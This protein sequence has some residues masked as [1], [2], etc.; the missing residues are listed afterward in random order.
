MFSREKFKTSYMF[1]TTKI[2]FK[3]KIL[4][5]KNI[6]MFDY[7]IKKIIFMKIDVYRTKH[8]KIIYLDIKKHT[9]TVVKI[10]G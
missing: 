10:I 7:E 4:F 3:K 6:Q 8:A 5:V 9:S 1:G 2:I